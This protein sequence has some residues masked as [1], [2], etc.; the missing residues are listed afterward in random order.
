MF[1]SGESEN[2]SSSFLHQANPRNNQI[3]NFKSDGEFLKSKGF[4]GGAGDFYQGLSHPPPPQQP[5]GLAR[6]RSA[7]SSFLAALLDSTTDNSSSGDES[8]AIFSAFMNNQKGGDSTNNNTHNHHQIQYQMKQEAGAG[9]EPHQETRPGFGGYE[10]AVSGGG[11]AIVGSYSMAAAA[12]AAAAMETTENGSNLMRQSSSPAGFFNGFGIMGDVGS[13]RVHNHPKPNPSSSGMNSNHMSFSSAPSS[14]SRFMPSIPENGSEGVAIRNSDQHRQLRSSEAS[15]GAGIFPDASWNTASSF[16]G[17]KRNRDGDVK[18]F[19]SFGGLENQNSDTR[20]NPSGLV[21]HLSLP[22][23]FS[24]AAEAEK[25]LQFQQDTVPCQIRAKRGC[26]THP[27]SIAERMRR[28]RI[29]ERMKKL[30]DLFPNM[31]KQTNTADMLDLAVEY[32]KD[33][34]KQVQTL[35]DTRAK[36]VCAN[37]PKQ[38]NPST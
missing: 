5:G 2:S 29:S 37:K 13:Y 14:T 17:L 20:K 11:G 10:T 18:M 24:E 21:H 9:S 35:T 26:A 19:P 6:Y 7:P 23:S 1:S 15:A 34:Q 16:N 32:I 3:P 4:H 12:A 33:L 8:E 36:C 27:R 31:D 30:Q 38:T 25:F 28:T 22:K